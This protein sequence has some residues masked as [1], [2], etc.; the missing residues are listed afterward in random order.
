MGRSNQSASAAAADGP[1]AA[2]TPAAVEP[3][4]KTR[5]DMSIGR[6]SMTTPSRMSTHG[7]GLF[8]LVQATALNMI[9]MIGVGPFITIPLLMTAL[10]GPQAMLGWA[11]ALV[12]VLCDAMV[13]SELGAAMPASGGTFRYLLEAF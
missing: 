5:R 13:W 7:S 3:T 11:V 1:S 9:N 8:G 2:A 4:R 6:T 10:G 12:V